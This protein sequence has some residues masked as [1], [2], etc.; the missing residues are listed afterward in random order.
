M[1]HQTWRQ[2]ATADFQKMKID[3][4]RRAK[5][6]L[7]GVLTSGVSVEDDDSCSPDQHGIKYDVIDFGGARSEGRK[8]T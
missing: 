6:Y 4:Q 7:V 3:E 2:M 5:L 1:Q 8:L